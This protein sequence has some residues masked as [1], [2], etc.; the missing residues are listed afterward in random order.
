MVHF[1]RL[2]RS[3]YL[4]SAT[5]LFILLAAPAATAG[6]PER[7][8]SLNLCADQMLLALGDP[9]RISGL[10]PLAHKPQVSFLA[11]KA[12]RYP[13]VRGGAEEIIRLRTDM[14][15][16]G[17]YDKPFVRLILRRRRIPYLELKPWP[18]IRAGFAQ[19]KVVAARLGQ[20]HRGDK[21]VSEIRTARAALQQLA[22][23]RSSSA[24]FLL[25]QRRG[26]VMQAGIT[27]E[28]LHLAGL[29][30]LSPRL[31]LGV[32]AIASLEEIAR[33][34]PD[35][36]VVESAAVDPSDQG[37]AKLLHPALRKLYP[38][39]RRI[40]IPDRLTVCAGPSTP[41]LIHHLAREI[42]RKVP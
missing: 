38:P 19:I 3:F 12:Q 26:Y 15:L 14:V 37:Q 30:D 35:F 28:L 25:I 42:A 7:V 20:P 31:R 22:G 41:S 9:A 11:K 29:T 32:S 16:L 24:T 27:L 23:R 13:L 39:A 5:G 6:A 34:R 4:T 1:R 18:D 21:L 8:V 40:L 33:Y 2:S 10:G 36:L 17:S